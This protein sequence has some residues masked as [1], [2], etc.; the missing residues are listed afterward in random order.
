MGRDLFPRS[1]KLA[2]LALRRRAD[3]TPG[4][5]LVAVTRRQKNVQDLAVCILDP[6]AWIKL[7]WIHR[8]STSCLAMM[9]DR[10]QKVRRSA[11]EFRQKRWLVLIA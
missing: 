8:E 1:R 6:L 3:R 11:G 7:K 2:V 4:P 10:A 9:V 5:R